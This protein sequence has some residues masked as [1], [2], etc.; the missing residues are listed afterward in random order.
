MRQ[1]I[2]K[3]KCCISIDID[4]Y[5]KLLSECDKYDAKISTRINSILKKYIKK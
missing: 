3:K 2:S 5:E 1:G 4:V